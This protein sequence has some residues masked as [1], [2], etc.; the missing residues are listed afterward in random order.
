MKNLWKAFERHNKTSKHRD[1]I[2]DYHVEDSVK[3]WELKRRAEGAAA[4]IININ[5]FDQPLALPS[6]FWAGSEKKFL[7]NHS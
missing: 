5:H 4:I 1:I 3:T 2:F 7:I 6:K